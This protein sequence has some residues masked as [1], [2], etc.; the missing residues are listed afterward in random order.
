[1]R[2][3]VPERKQKIHSLLIWGENFKRVA[4]IIRFAL[5]VEEGR[6]VNNSMQFYDIDYSIFYK[7]II[8][9]NALIYFI[10]HIKRYGPE[11]YYA[12]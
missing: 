9:Y 2:E 11:R 7:I 6:F 12:I 10:N 5:A 8:F 1:V 4:E 3:D